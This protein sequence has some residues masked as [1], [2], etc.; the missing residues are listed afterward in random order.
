MS[1]KR[2]YNLK[3]ER[4]HPD[5]LKLMTLP[6]NPSLPSMVDLRN[7]MPPVFD[8][9][10]LGSCTANA[11][12]G[13]VGYDLPGFIGSRLF[14]YYNE[15]TIEGDVL[16]DSGALLS[17]G[18]KCLQTYGICPET[19]W[20][21]IISQ[22]AVKPQQQCYTDALKHKAISVQHINNDVTSMKNALAAGNP[23]VVGIVVYQSFETQTVTETGMVPMP[24]PNDKVLGGHAVV[25]VGYN[26]AKQLW[27]MRNSWGTSWGLNGYFYL[28][29]NYLL[30]SNLATDLWCVKTMQQ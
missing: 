12:C 13:V 22:F 5:K 18:V 8:Q 30:K 23:F 25:C 7:K 20:P 2:S 10:Q 29:Y 28:P 21:Y 14:L 17:D 26:D 4:L 6:I 9:G 11:L 24:Q 1:V 15:R 3:I 27:I 16:H 19:E